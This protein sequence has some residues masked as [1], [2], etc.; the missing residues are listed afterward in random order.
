MPDTL[1]RIFFHRPNVEISGILVV[2]SM[3]VAVNILHLVPLGALLGFAVSELGAQTLISLPR[4]KESLF[5]H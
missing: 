2:N 1:I 5:C 3:N 4:E